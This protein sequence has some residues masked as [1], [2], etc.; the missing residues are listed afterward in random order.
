LLTA[1]IPN[2]GLVAGAI[3]LI[4]NVF[5]IVISKSPITTILLTGY[6]KKIF[7]WQ[8]IKNFLV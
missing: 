6:Q 4:A 8:K 7:D 1:N 5:D 2:G 3:V